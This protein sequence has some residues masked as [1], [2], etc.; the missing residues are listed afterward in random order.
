M[1]TEEGAGNKS[2]AGPAEVE[3]AGSEAAGGDEE[4]AEQEAPGGVQEQGK[5]SAVTGTQSQCTGHLGGGSE[6]QSGGEEQAVNSGSSGNDSYP[7]GSDNG[8]RQQIGDAEGRSGTAE[9]EQEETMSREA[10]GAGRA[11]WQALEGPDDA[12]V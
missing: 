7:D 2:V 12:D 1:V 11:A 10:A 5:S 6:E 3:A 9:L 8:I 4:S